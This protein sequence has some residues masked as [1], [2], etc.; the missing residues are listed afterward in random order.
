M[1]FVRE[2]LYSQKKLCL[3]QSFGKLIIMMIGNIDSAWI[4]SWALDFLLYAYYLV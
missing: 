1:G 4:L 3:E 2:G